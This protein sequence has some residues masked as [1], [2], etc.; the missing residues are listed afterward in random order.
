VFSDGQLKIQR[1][2]AWIV[3]I[4]GKGLHGSNAAGPGR[5]Y[6]AAHVETVVV[7]ARTG[8]FIESVLA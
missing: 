4:W 3:S 1:R 6:V 7:D 5:P 8:H 2:P